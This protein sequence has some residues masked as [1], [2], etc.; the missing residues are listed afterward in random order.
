MAEWLADLTVLLR[1]HSMWELLNLAEMMAWLLALWSA[2]LR[3]CCS[4]EQR[5]AQKGVS[6]GPSWES[7]MMGLS[8]AH[9]LV[10]RTGP[11]K[12]GTR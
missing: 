9:C 1:V 4:A 2:L 8:M 6:W 10:K 7:M 3:A 5:A 11:M 12:M